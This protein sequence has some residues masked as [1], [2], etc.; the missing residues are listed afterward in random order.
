MAQHGPTLKHPNINNDRHDNAS[1][2][3]DIK[4]SCH[5]IAVLALTSSSRGA[6]AMETN[7]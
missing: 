1:I 7:P 2:T 3:D 4:E 6:I 5:D